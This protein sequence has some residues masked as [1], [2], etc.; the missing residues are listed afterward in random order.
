MVSQVSDVVERVVVHDLANCGGLTARDGLDYVR[1]ILG[2]CEEG[3]GV[4]AE[5]SLER[6]TR[7]ERCRS[8]THHSILFILELA[9][10]NPDD[11]ASTLGVELG[12]DSAGT[13]LGI[14]SAVLATHS[15]ALKEDRVL[16]PQL[17]PLDVDGVA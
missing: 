17:Q 14:C 16:V 9:C 10:V 15:V 1:I 11:V 5:W 7:G 8:A 13:A 6:G 2:A 12:D 4:A 3:W